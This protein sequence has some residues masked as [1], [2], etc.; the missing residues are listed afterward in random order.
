MICA[1]RMP[2]ARERFLA[3]FVA[4]SALLSGCY[5]SGGG[6]P[7]PPN[8]FYYPVGVAVSQGGNV[9]YAINSDFD[10]QWN[11]GTLQSYDLHLIRKHT[12]LAIANPADPNLPLTRPQPPPGSCPSNPPVNASDGTGRQ[13][14]GQTCAPPI[15]S[16]FY[17]RD[18]VVVG[19]FA[20]DLQR[21]VL[22]TR[23]FAPV[24]GDASLTWADIAPDDPG[25]APPEDPKVRYAPFAIDCGARTSDNRCAPDHHA[26][27]NPFEPG[28]ARNLTMPGEPFGM[29][30]SEDGQSLVIT[31][32][33]S[34]NASL[35]STGFDPSL[36]RTPS[37]QYVL[38]TVPI[39]A[40]AAV[41]VPH[42]PQAFA[43]CV[44]LPP[45]M[46]C[47]DLPRP[48]FLVTNRSSTEV[49]L[50]RDYPGD[51]RSSG[52]RPYIVKEESFGLTVN[53]GGTDSRGI[54]VDTTP[55]I[56]CKA[57]VPPAD[58][59]ASPPRTQADVDADLLACARKPAR[60]F[61]TNRTPDTL[62]LGE[63][64]EGSTTGDGTYDPDRLTIFGNEPLSLGSSRVY[65]APIV[66]SDGNY[67]V[68]VFIVCF[69]SAR[70]YV[71]DPDA[72]TMEAIIRVGLGPFAM[73][74]DPFSLEDVALHRKVLDDP[75]E[76]AIGLK[77]YR[78]AYVASFTDSYV[79]VIDLDNS[80]ADKSTF[81]TVVYTLGSPQ[82]P[83]GQQ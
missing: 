60:V 16:T 39:S 7:P 44:E 64:G 69:D 72:G 62:L 20:T 38:S 26:G 18:S 42:D 9:L 34:N 63:V 76:P 31:H 57:L 46:P 17:V 36:P 4:L 37:L 75:R 47:P 71:F 13:Q 40:N 23:L 81:E 77:S 49:D 67:A 73:A 5:S 58:P 11:G 41:A 22:G 15:D 65:V 53:A 50:L 70:I 12:V 55:R 33:N 2:R 45:G 29:A 61:I 74:F 78:F 48:A 52:T 51:G 8:R 79:Q 35:F 1:T 83:I 10:L 80:R 14:L 56:A 30:Q 68:R 6:T 59:S 19:A 54:A 3:A 82:T 66:D 32:L 28:N 43:D 27:T 21:S 25:V 24:R